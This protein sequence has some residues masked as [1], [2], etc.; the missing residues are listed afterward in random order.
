M[1]DPA[2][3]AHHKL[4]LIDFLCKYIN[5]LLRGSFHVILPP[6]PGSSAARHR[7]RNAGPRRTSR[8]P[9]AYSPDIQKSYLHT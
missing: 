7:C 9:T 3:T 1:A 2:K 6:P 4:Q 5:L 8:A